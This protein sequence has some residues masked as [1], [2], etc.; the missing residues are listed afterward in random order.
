MAW[1]ISDNPFWLIILTVDT[2]EAKQTAQAA[3]SPPQAIHDGQALLFVFCILKKHGGQP[4][5][6]I[7]RVSRGI[8]EPRA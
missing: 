4:Y 5:F 1:R 2:A 8:Q 7:P 6:V 3:V